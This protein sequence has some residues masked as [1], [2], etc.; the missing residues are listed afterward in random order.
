MPIIDRVAEVAE[1]RGVPM[2]QIA[3]AWHLNRGVESPTLGFSKP[4]RVDDAVAAVDIG[5][6]KDEMDYMEEPYVAHELVGPIGHPGEK[7]IA[8]TIRPKA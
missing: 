5:L 1:S 6:A 7:P 4:T 8:G 3:I 2:A